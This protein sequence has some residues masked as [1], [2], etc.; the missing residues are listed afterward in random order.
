LGKWPLGSGEN[1]T[2]NF[3]RA[4]YLWGKGGIPGEIIAIYLEALFL[5]QERSR[6]CSPWFIVPPYKGDLWSHKMQ[7]KTL[8]EKNPRVL[9]PKNTV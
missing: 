1:P 2:G 3:F 5:D 9:E 6:V 4:I 8:R 7:R